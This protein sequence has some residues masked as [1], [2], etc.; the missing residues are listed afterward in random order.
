MSP[1]ALSLP[2]AVKEFEKRVIVDALEQND[3]HKI[4][5]ARMLGIPRS[6]LHRKIKEYG[7]LE[8]D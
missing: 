1:K 7:L 5:T 4:N 2:E 8:F 3:R 6:T